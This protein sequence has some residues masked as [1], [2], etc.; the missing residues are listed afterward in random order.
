MMEGGCR[1]SG[2]SELKNLDWKRWDVSGMI[3]YDIS[4]YE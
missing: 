1:K 2:I 4:G 3:F